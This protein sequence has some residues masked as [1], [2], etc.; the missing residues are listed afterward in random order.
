MMQ[1]ERRFE[2]GDVLPDLQVLTAQGGVYNLRDQRLAGDPIALVCDGAGDPARPPGE[3]DLASFAEAGAH[4]L[5]IRCAEPDPTESAEATWFDP[6]RLLPRLFGFEAPAIVVI[7][8]AFRLEAVLPDGAFDRASELARRHAA[9]PAPLLGAGTAPVLIVPDVLD[10]PLIDRLIGYWQGGDKLK[11]SVSANRAATNVTARSDFKRRADVLISDKELFTA[12]KNRIL[13][14]LAPLMQR[15]FAFDLASMEALRIG[16]YDAADAGFFRRHR[17]NA[18][19]F[20]AQRKFAMSL[21]L[22]T[23]AYEGGRLTFLEFGRAQYDAPPGG[24]VVFSCSLLHEA[25]VVTQGQ[26]FAVFTF[27]TDAEGARRQAEMQKAEKI[28]PRGGVK[29]R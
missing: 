26:R 11:D 12:V 19:R 27:F 29:I 23:G 20:T 1:A 22:N 18:T 13:T 25:G 24:A 16:C 21:N 5:R 28:D 2:I 10:Q 6:K 4:L 14:R 3:A 8:P 7:S 9:A 15:A 17:D